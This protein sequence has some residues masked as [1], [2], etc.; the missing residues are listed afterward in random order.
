MSTLTATTYERGFRELI[1]RG[2]AEGVFTTRSARLK[3]VVVVDEA[4]PAGRVANA[5]IC[6]AAATATSVTGLIGPAAGTPAARCIR[7]CRGP[8]ARCWARP[9]DDC[10]RSGPGR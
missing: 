3:W 10:G 8:A 1:E 7:G 6:V 5:A 2:A 9:P 4:M